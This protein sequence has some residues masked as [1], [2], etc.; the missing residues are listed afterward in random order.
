MNKRMIFVCLSLIF[1]SAVTW[2]ALGTG[3]LKNKNG[4]GR[5][6]VIA[7]LFP[8]YDFARTIGGNNAE[9]T[10]LLPPGTEAHAY[11]PKPGDIQK[12]SQADVFIYTGPLM[13][14]WVA[15]ILESIYN[16]DLTIVNASE[17]I[18]LISSVTKG[19][20]T[21][22]G[23]LD[24]HIWLDFTNDLIIVDHI[25]EAMSNR[26]S[27]QKEA[28]AASAAKL[29]DDLRQLDQDFTSTL[30]TCQSRT[31]VYGG[32]FAL[33]YLTKRYDLTYLAA[34]GLSPDSEPSASDLTA[35]VDDIR[36]RGVK[37]VF[38]EELSSP[39]IAETI[40]NE[41]SASLLELSAAHNISKRDLD[42]G[43]TFI[44]IMRS[45]LDHLRQG[46]QC[47]TL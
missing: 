38:Y 42:S 33:G 43:V 37:T 21:T 34:Q 23:T 7:T 28:F 5:V 32:H 24:P 16:P 46:L 45:D 44:S 19:T 40:A 27:A 14:P 18:E 35:L 10:L 39:R 31:V 1:L 41:T 13:E 22:E 17:G 8:L 9:V 26:D 25:T 29:K 30:S 3:N 6:Q 11:E 4:S 20:D 47:Q 15:D 36:T 2:W 12:I